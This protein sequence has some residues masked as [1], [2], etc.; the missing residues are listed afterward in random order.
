MK[1]T[2]IQMPGGITNFSLWVCLW[3]LTYEGREFGDFVC[4]VLQIMSLIPSD[5]Q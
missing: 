4:F 5:S 3:G 1:L 2:S